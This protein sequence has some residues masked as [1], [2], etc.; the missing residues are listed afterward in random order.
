LPCFLCVPEYERCAEDDQLVPPDGGRGGEPLVLQRDE[1]RHVGRVPVRLLRC[2]LL[3]ERVQ[4]R[5]SS[6]PT[7]KARGGTEEI[8]KLKDLEGV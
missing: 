4:A 3:Q 7:G 5:Q 2:L 6:F 8:N 1:E